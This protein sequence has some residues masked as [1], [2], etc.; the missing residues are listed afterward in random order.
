MES[1]A[2]NAMAT[3]GED[4]RIVRLAADDDR[5]PAEP[6]EELGGLAG[7]VTHSLRNHFH[8]LYYWLDLLAEEKLGEEAR[9]ALEGTGAAIAAV[10]RLTTGA[11]ALCRPVEL[12]PISMDADEV[13]HGVEHALRRLGARVQLEC[14]D[15]A[16]RRVAIDASHFS[17]TI[18]IVGA[19]LGAGESHPTAITVRGTVDDDGR[20]VLTMHAAVATADDADAIEELL[21]WGQAQR[22]VRRH[23]GALLWEVAGTTE[24][25][26]VLLLPATQ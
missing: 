19:R 17:Q 10:E 16:G 8:R 12:S 9:A 23:G 11:M 6:A 7:D 22:V 26:A 14:A 21:E 3:Y 15:L 5:T 18:E 13:V 25:R 4:V 1:D 2:A 24:R 20:L